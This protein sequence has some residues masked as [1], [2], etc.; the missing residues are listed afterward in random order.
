MPDFYKCLRPGL[1]LKVIR[2][3]MVSET[4]DIVKSSCFEDVSAGATETLF[5]TLRIRNTELLF[6][7]R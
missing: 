5:Q 4:I 6:S 1:K 3:I 2:A 7:P